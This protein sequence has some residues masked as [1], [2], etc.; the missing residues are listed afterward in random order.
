MAAELWQ[1]ATVVVDENYAGGVA[2]AFSVTEYPAFCLVDSEGTV[3]AVERD[4]AR[5]AAPAER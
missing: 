4:V 2:R 3:L 5:L 1:V